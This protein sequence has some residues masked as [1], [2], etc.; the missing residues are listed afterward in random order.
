MSA[1]MGAPWPDLSKTSRRISPHNTIP[2]YQDQSQCDTLDK[3]GKF[4]H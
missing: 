2:G 1:S 4:G 3:F